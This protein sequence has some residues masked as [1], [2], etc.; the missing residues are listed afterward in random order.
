MRKRVALLLL[1]ALVFTSVWPEANA[2]ATAKKPK[3]NVKKLNMTVGNTFQMRIYNM[4]KKY[5]V[6]YT[7]S[8][9]A[10]AT[11][12]ALAPNGKRASI[13][14]L[15][16]GSTTVTATIRKGRKLIRILKCKVKVSPNAISI[17]FMMRKSKVSV[18]RK[19][20]LETIIKPNTSEEQ[21]VFESSDPSIAIVNSRGV[22]TGISPGTVTITATLLSCDL[23][24]SCTITVLPNEEYESTKIQKSATNDLFLEQ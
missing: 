2:Q 12:K 13:N 8:K 9:P 1:F 3:L 20:R 16:V 15:A 10:I 5:K 4:K 22:V 23:S 14:A 18:D 17:K 7:S 21:P 6:T 11:V 19:M 24:T